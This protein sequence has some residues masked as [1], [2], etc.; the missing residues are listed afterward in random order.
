MLKILINTLLGVILIFIWSRF[1]DLKQIMTVISKVNLIYLLP[2]FL[3]MF[4]S[5]II[6]ALR[7]K[8]FLA[9]IP[10]KDRPSSGWKKISLK[11]LIYLNGVAMMLN[12]FI[13]IRAGEIAKGIYLNTQYKLDLKKGIV[14]VF[15]DRFVDFLAVLLIAGIITMQISTNLP[16]SFQLTTLSISGFV[17][18]VIYFVVFQI[19]FSRK[20]I[21]F[22][23]PLLIEKHIKIYFDKFTSFILDSFAILKRKPKDLALIILLTIVAYIVD[24]C[25]WFLIFISLGFPQDFMKMFLG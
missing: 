24:A 7:L 15:L 5:P 13:P 10:V 23:R 3:F 20:I 4:L 11:D 22:L 25:I 18:V 9:E 16:D 12:F 14:W 8:V 1:V 6:R 21:N 17:L 2:V 19:G